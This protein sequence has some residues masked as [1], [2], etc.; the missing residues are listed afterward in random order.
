M[1]TV[2]III[3]QPCVHMKVNNNHTAVL[4]MKYATDLTLEDDRSLVFVNKL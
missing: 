2:I 4:A 3:I 1:Y